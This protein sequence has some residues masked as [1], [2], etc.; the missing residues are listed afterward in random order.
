MA[1]S[2]GK[3]RGA[4][5][6]MTLPIADS[7]RLTPV[8]N[9]K[10]ATK[11]SPDVIAKVN[12]MRILLV[13]DDEDS[14]DMLGMALSIYGIFVEAA[15][16]AVEALEKLQAHRPDVLVSDIGL[17]G[18][19]GYDLIRKVRA[20]PFN[21]GGQIPA[22]ALT[23]YVSM[24]DRNLAL[25]AGYQDHLPKPVDPNMLLELLAKLRDGRERAA[26]LA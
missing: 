10:R 6:T 12:G 3:D 16:S 11:I 15:A 21:E 9:G 14:R 13:E 23:G 25:A 19:D 24:Q 4:V 2:E 18:E 1:H 26:D 5:F 17:P 8:T 20:Q 7:K 22:I